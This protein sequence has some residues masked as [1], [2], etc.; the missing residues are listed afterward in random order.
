MSRLE[1]RTPVKGLDLSSA[2][3]NPGG[4]FGGALAGAK[5]AFKNLVEDLG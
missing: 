5:G 1:N 4:G 2:W 3:G